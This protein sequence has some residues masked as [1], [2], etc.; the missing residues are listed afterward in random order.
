[1]TTIHD[2]IEQDT[3]HTAVCD[4]TSLRQDQAIT[5]RLPN[6]TNDRAFSVVCRRSKQHGQ[7]HVTSD[8]GRL[9]TSCRTIS[10]NTQQQQLSFH[11]KPTMRRNTERKRVERLCCCNYHKRGSSLIPSIRQLL[12]SP[13]RHL[14]TSLATFALPKFKDY[15]TIVLILIF[16]LYVPS[17]LAV[18]SSSEPL[19]RTDGNYTFFPF[20]CSSV[21]SFTQKLILLFFSVQH[22]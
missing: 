10:S 20:L 1:M 21:K 14:Q 12:S 11:F 6:P 9:S 19:T 8:S 16:S 13:Q 3:N 18:S 5:V 15:L 4:V 7:D 22:D 2:L 17:T